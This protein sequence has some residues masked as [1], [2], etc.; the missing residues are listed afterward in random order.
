MLTGKGLNEPEALTCMLDDQLMCWLPCKTPYPQRHVLRTPKYA[1]AVLRCSC[2]GLLSCWTP[3]GPR[4]VPRH[5]LNRL[6][7][8]Y[9]LCIGLK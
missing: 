8:R 2:L 9:S 6:Q 3:P 7:C 4:G 1:L 5:H